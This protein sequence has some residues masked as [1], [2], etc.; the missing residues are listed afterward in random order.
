MLDLF[1][2]LTIR[3]M[4]FLNYLIYDLNHSRKEKF[5]Y[6][7]VLFVGVITMAICAQIGG[8]VAGV[9]C[10]ITFP[11]LT[12]FYFVG[13]MY[14]SS[15]F[16]KPFRTKQTS[17]QF[18]ML[19]AS[20]T[21]KFFAR[22]INQCVLPILIGVISIGL[23]IGLMYLVNLVVDLEACRYINIA[24]LSFRQA[25]EN[26]PVELIARI[27]SIAPLYGLLLILSG[28]LSWFE[29]MLG[30]LVFGK[31][32]F[33]KTIVAVMILQWLMAPIVMGQGIMPQMQVTTNDPTFVLDVFEKL[34]NWRVIGIDLAG[35]IILG[36]ISFIL[37]K[38]KTIL[39]TGF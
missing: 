7:L 5:I 37:F 23:A 6:G 14:M 11:L 26:A 27:N 28:I 19:P 39:K 34:L 16:G 36:V 2:H 3:I 29:Y 8:V 21:E 32:A 24:I 35:V 13:A 38:N 33:I 10:G 17:I 15:H 22:F 20:V 12:M 9:I 1:N 18:L 31:Y 4:R 30:S 25:L